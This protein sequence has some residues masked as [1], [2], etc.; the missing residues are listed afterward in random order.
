[1]AIQTS[2]DYKVSGFDLNGN[3]V[4]SDWG[5]IYDPSKYNPMTNAPYK[6]VNEMSFATKDVTTGTTVQPTATFWSTCKSVIEWIVSLYN[7]LGIK[8]G[9]TLENTVPDGNEWTNLNSGNS[10]AGI[11]TYL[12]IVA[13]AAI[14]YYL[15][16][17]TGD[18]KTT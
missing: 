7:S 16:T 5:S 4:K 12:P 6:S 14:V 15:F 3:Y 1:V 8:H 13:G 18:K 2:L 9:Q 10:E 17:N 11:G